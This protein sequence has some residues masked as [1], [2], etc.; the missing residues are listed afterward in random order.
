MVLAV[1]L[2]LASTSAR[3]E[4]HR[5]ALR[6]LFHKTYANAS[7]HP[8]LSQSPLLVAGVGPQECAGVDG[9]DQPQRADGERDSQRQPEQRPAPAGVDRRPRPLELLHQFAG[10][11]DGRRAGLHRGCWV[12]A[13]ASPACVR[14]RPPPRASCIGINISISIITDPRLA[15]QNS[16]SEDDGAARPAHKPAWSCQ[17]KKPGKTEHG[18]R[19]P[20]E[21][22]SFFPSFFLS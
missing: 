5:Q 21:D 10:L 6:T 20:W 15:R 18:S 13:V 16:E 11:P 3:T 1:A 22:M 12:S 4:N 14:A 9:D 7:M 2:A 8:I 19:K 17:R